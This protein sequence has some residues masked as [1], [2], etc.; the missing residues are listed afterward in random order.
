MSRAEPRLAWAYVA[1]A[2]AGTASESVLAPELAR[3]RFAASG[4]RLDPGGEETEY[5]LV[6]ITAYAS[7]PRGR[8]PR[9]FCPVCLERVILRLGTRNRHHYGHRPDAHCAAA[10]GEGALHLSAKIHLARVLASG[11][12]ELRIRYVCARVPEERTLE[13]CTESAPVTIPLV[14]DEVRVEYAVPSLRADVMLL[15]EGK[16]AGAIEIYAHHVVDSA[17][18]EKYHRLGLPWVEVPAR[19]LLPEGGLAWE[20]SRPLPA[21]QDSTLHPVRWR[22]PRHQALHEGLLA[23]QQSGIHRL[24]GRVVHLYRTD[25]GRSTGETRVR[26]T[27]VF[28][29][30]RREAGQIAEAW[31]ERADTESRVGLPLRTTDRVAARRHL[32]QQ[33]KGWVRWMRERG[34]VVDSPM[35]WAD[36]RA[37]EGW[38]RA[39]HTYPERLRRDVHRGDF[40]ALPNTGPVAWPRVEGQRGK[41]ADPLLG[42][43]DCTWT[44][45]H[46]QKRPLLQACAGRVWLA[47]RVQ[48][49]GP[50]TGVGSIAHA[51]LFVHD[52]A[53]WR[54]APGAPFVTEQSWSA[55]GSGALRW[56][57]L[58]REA[59]RTLALLPPEDLLSGTD[60]PARVFAAL[61]PP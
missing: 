18:A 50:G 36:P 2:E 43:A 33:F 56:A 4:E 59:A 38:E 49:R 28:M 31:L 15:R 16:E 5:L 47:L 7:L 52:G 13:R 27:V 8:R 9:A 42:Y 11:G 3:R 37:L 22:C 12:S 10:R 60:A 17:R 32:H 57:T 23:H 48:A 39:P 35:R 40:Q 29:T 19:A 61:A 6:P 26:A 25:G 46:P 21:L 53:R 51:S 1:R 44:Q 58:L 34:V 41:G 20:P 14:W 30:E 45:L 55:G 54:A 24:A